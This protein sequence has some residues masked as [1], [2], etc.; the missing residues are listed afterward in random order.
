M[1]TIEKARCL[2]RNVKI[3]KRKENDGGLFLRGDN[4]TKQIAAED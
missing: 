1:T 3:Q 2:E 4:V